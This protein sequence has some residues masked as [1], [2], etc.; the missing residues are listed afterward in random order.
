MP[1]SAKAFAADPYDFAEA[2]ALS[3]AL[4]LSR[5]VA[6]TLVR[7]GYRTP[8]E[9]R[10]FLAADESH[11]PDAFQGM[12]EIAG[13]VWAAIEAGERITVHGDFDVDGVSATALMI[14]TLRDLGADCDWLI[15]DRIADGYGLSSENVEKLARRGTGLLITVDCGITAAEQVRQAQD[16]GMEVIVTDHHQRDEELPPCLILH[17]EVSGYPFESLC[18]TAVAWKLA[19]ALREGKSADADL[20]LVALATVAD[21]V[22]LV[23]ENRSLVK[24]GLAEMQRTR[25]VGLRALLEA[26]K[27]DPARLDE[28]DLG[29]RLAPRIN[30]AG[31]LYRADAGVELLLTDDEER[32]KQIAE[33]LGRANSERR[34]TEREVDAAAEAARRELPGELKEANGLVLAGEG[35]HPGVVGIVASRLVER[36]H[37]PVV[38]ISLDGKGGG[39]G[40]G[41]SIPGFDLHGALEACSEHLESFGGHKAAAGLSL[42]A[43]NLEAFR[44]AFAAHAGEVLGPDDLKRT[45][46]IDAMVGGVGLGLDLAEE[47]GRLAPFGMG[48]PGVRL[49]VPSARVTDVRTMG[50]EGKHARFSLHSGSHRALGVAFGRSSLGVDDEDVLDAAVRL[51]VNHWNG[52]V[53]PRVVLREVYPLAVDAD[54]LAPHPCECSEAEWWQRFEAE[55]S[56]DLDVTDAAASAADRQGPPRQVVHGTASSPTATIAE[57]VSSGAGVLA[58][59]ADASRRA[60]LAN[61]ATG[62]ARFNGG[63]AMIACHRCGAEAVAGLAARADNGLA[64]VDYAALAPAPDLAASFEHVVLVDAPRTPLDAARVGVP[65][66]GPEPAPVPPPPANDKAALLAVARA[67]MAGETGD[68]GLDEPERRGPGFLHPL[69]SAAEQ[70]FGLGVLARQAPSRETIGGVFRALRSAGQASGADLRGTLAGLGPHPL[71]PETAARCFR[72]LRELG[73]VTGDTSAGDGLVGVVSSEGTDLGRSAAFRA[74]SQEH[75]EAQSFLQSQKSP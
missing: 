39:R 19:C 5:P 25:R 65:L 7:R 53:E 26:S 51:E 23:G 16:L 24:R 27:C 22:P 32:A 8:A 9:A 66:A 55:L 61:G 57:L 18:G 34:A 67:A 31:R 58:V 3:D 46:R 64:L 14:S 74:Y 37:R 43:E 28:G 36:H 20:D 35:W 69:F 29:F 4:G 71:A 40:S 44:V 13:L 49:M 30:A 56:R 42:R 38:V 63:A 70:E 75:S 54:A 48:N 11:P 12:D 59:T 17:P 1:D 15:P 72:V 21:V 10:A 2:R 62:L 73:L 52:A 60:A 47:L 45:E 68:A 41:R 33:E 50:E 6:V